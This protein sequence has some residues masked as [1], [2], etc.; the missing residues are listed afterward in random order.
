MKE[1][2]VQITSFEYIV[3]ELYALYIHVEEYYWNF[4]WF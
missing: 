4:Q 3:C 1:T 2:T